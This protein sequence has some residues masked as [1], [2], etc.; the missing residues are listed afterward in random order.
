MQDFFKY[1][2]NKYETIQEELLP[3][4]TPAQQAVLGTLGRGGS[5]P[6][7]PP[8]SIRIPIHLMVRWTTVCLDYQETER[9]WK[10]Y[11]EYT[12]YLELSQ[13]LE[14]FMVTCMIRMGGGSCRGHPCVDCL[15]KEMESST[16]VAHLV[17]ELRNRLDANTHAVECY[18]AFKL[19]WKERMEHHDLVLK[20]ELVKFT[21][22]VLGN[23]HE[24]MD[25]FSSGEVKTIEEM[26]PFLQQDVRGKDLYER[27][28]ELELLTNTTS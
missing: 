5:S 17:P 19:V 2:K 8:P 3:Y 24:Y 12:K 15:V 16:K 13:G 4:L 26:V 20:E 18:R 21:T 10:V 14:Q 27:Y 28:Q 7:F 6:P 23:T 25:Y 22:L 11:E 1:M 9:L